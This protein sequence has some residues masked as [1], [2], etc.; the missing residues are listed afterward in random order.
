M[1]IDTIEAA[2]DSVNPNAWS[3]TKYCALK[4]C[5]AL[6]ELNT[7]V[8]CQR[9]LQ[10]NIFAEITNEIRADIHAAMV[11]VAIANLTKPHDV[12]GAGVIYTNELTGVCHK[13]SLVYKKI[14]I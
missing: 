2:Y 12:A 9:V 1:T 11:K 6:V 13:Y 10:L 8:A 7:Y 14:C 3:C 4:L 5:N